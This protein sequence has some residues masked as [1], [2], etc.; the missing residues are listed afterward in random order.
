MYFG[1]ISYEDFMVYMSETI[2]R[3]PRR[4]M[5]KYFLMIFMIIVIPVLGANPAS[6]ETHSTTVTSEYDDESQDN[7][8]F[9]YNIEPSSCTYP[10]SGDSW[11]AEVE[12]TNL[13][14]NT[15]LAV[16]LGNDKGSS[17]DPGN[18]G[19]LYATGNGPNPTV[20]DLIYTFEE[21]GLSEAITLTIMAP[22]NNGCQDWTPSCDLV[23]LTNPLAR[24]QDGSYT[25]GQVIDLDTQLVD[26]DGRVKHVVFDFTRSGETKSNN[27]I[28]GPETTVSWT[29]AWADSW[30]VVV[31]LLGE[32]GTEIPHTGNCMLSFVISDTGTTN[33]P[34]YIDPTHVDRLNPPDDTLVSSTEFLP[35]TGKNTSLMA[36]LG[37]TLLT[38]GFVFNRLGKSSI[39]DPKWTAFQNEFRRNV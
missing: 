16:T 20:V 10:Y 36:I 13:S 24:N 21:P 8:Q 12:I 14:G 18:S 1:H 7:L 27:I 26:P 4:A 37:F 28:S 31:R 19:S 29:A 17:I 30:N 22:E 32:D 15:N 34:E 35:E 39:V 6:A 5:R 2:H 9:D 33:P 38:V 23:D 3:T 25:V 11:T